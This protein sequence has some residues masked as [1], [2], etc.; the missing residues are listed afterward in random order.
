MRYSIGISCGIQS[1]KIWITFTI[2]AAAGKAHAGLMRVGL[3][4]NA[5]DDTQLVV[6]TSKKSIKQEKELITS[7]KEVLGK[8]ALGEDEIE[9]IF[10]ILEKQNPDL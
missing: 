6:I 1:R 9:N 10:D 8:L 3:M 4:V 7:G 5:I 2:T